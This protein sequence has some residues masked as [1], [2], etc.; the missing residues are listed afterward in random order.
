MIGDQEEEENVVAWDA[1][2]LQEKQHVLAIITKIAK[3]V[4]NNIDEENLASF[5]SSSAQQ[6]PP[7]DSELAN[8]DASTASNSYSE[9]NMDAVSD[10][11]LKK[12]SIEM[13]EDGIRIRTFLNYPKG[14]VGPYY[15][16]EVDMVKLID[17][18]ECPNLDPLSNRMLL[19]GSLQNVA[20]AQHEYALRLEEEHLAKVMKDSEEME[21]AMEM[22]SNEETKSDTSWEDCKDDD[23]NQ[24]E[25]GNDLN[26]NESLNSSEKDGDLDGNG[27]NDDADDY[28]EQMLE[29]K[30]VKLK[31]I[32]DLAIE[33]EHPRGLYFAG[34]KETDPLVKIKYLQMSSDLGWPEAAYCLGMIY[35]DPEAEGCPNVEKDLDKALHYFTLVGDHTATALYH[36]SA[37]YNQSVLIESKNPEQSLDLCKLAIARGHPTTTQAANSIDSLSSPRSVPLCISGDYIIRYLWLERAYD[38]CELKDVSQVPELIEL[39]VETRLILPS[40]WDKA[41]SIVTKL[42]DYVEL[43]HA[44]KW[45]NRLFLK[46]K[47]NAFEFACA[48]HL[49]VDSEPQG[50]YAVAR[51]Y[52][53]G[54]DSDGKRAMDAVAFYLKT[55]KVCMNQEPTISKNFGNVPTTNSHAIKRT[56]S[57]ISL[58]GLWELF[59]KPEI[60]YDFTKAWAVTQDQPLGETY[61]KLAEQ[62]LM[63][64]NLSHYELSQVDDRNECLAQIDTKT[65]RVAPIWKPVIKENAGLKRVFTQISGRK[66]TDVDVDVPTLQRDHS[67]TLNSL[68]I[69]NSSRDDVDQGGSG[70]DNIGVKIVKFDGQ[71]GN[72][73]VSKNTVNVEEVDD[74][75]DMTLPPLFV[76]YSLQFVD[77]KLEEK[78]QCLRRKNRLYEI[79]KLMLFTGI[80]TKITLV[81]LISAVV[82]YSMTLFITSSKWKRIT[83]FLSRFYLIVAFPVFNSAVYYEYEYFFYPNRNSDDSSFSCLA[84]LAIG[85]EIFLMCMLS[86]LELSSGISVGVAI[87]SAIT[88]VLLFGRGYS[89]DELLTP[90]SVY[91]TGSI[92][93][94]MALWYR[95]KLNRKVF[96]YERVIERMLGIPQESLIPIRSLNDLKMY[97]FDKKT[98]FT[99]TIKS[100]YAC[101]PLKSNPEKQLPFVDKI[102]ETTY[103]KQRYTFIVTVQVL[104][105]A[106]YIGAAIF[107]VYLDIETYMHAQWSHFEDVDPQYKTDA[108][109]DD[110]KRLARQYQSLA[111]IQLCAGIMTGKRFFM[112]IAGI[113]C[114]FTVWYLVSLGQ[115][116]PSNNMSYLSQI[117]VFSGFSVRFAADEEKSD[118]RLFLLQTFIQNEEM[119]RCG[120]YNNVS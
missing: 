42:K 47:S 95:E 78:F 26:E 103:I 112:G 98:D 51:A 74:T 22:D 13:R 69:C 86:D 61:R 67:L 104:S 83:F 119:R 38:V 27:T 63:N 23:D 64:P 57:I 102:L 100:T 2:D 44:F 50:L 114:I 99:S 116:S 58:L 110:T 11:N 82:T 91:L 39:A 96:G 21:S 62:L 77:K 120:H 84:E 70:G 19:N 101:N 89:F 41:I 36:S 52:H 90:V 3:I 29:Q 34:A 55:I 108:F 1:M 8:M 28:F 35:K 97:L 49:A 111:L 117:V 76:R 92:I 46:K 43:M 15:A 40:L 18:L 81:Q 4:D 7:A 85:M 53:Y 59:A 5:L 107:H 93:A 66:F 16:T 71:F 80:S 72:R 113:A 118:R 79:R 14:S 73:S 45:A 37:L 17:S 33:A 68:P 25:E 12:K 6:Q 54:L 75:F 60:S 24:E 10:R 31:A 88:G 115:V 30:D 65:T 56:L 94:I 20:T 9:I 48:L 105:L 106:L 87:A 32:R 109:G